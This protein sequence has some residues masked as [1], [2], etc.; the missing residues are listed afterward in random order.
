MQNLLPWLILLACPLM[1]I[2][3]MRGMGGGK[4]HSGHMAPSDARRETDD[5]RDRR[6]ADLEREIVSLRKA[7]PAARAVV[8]LDTV[9]RDGS[10]R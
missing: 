7:D 6:I 3:L 1:M 4:G 10:P 8:G 9:G 2:F 5:E